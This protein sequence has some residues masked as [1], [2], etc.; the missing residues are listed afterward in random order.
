MGMERI[1]LYAELMSYGSNRLCGRRNLNIA[2]P[3]LFVSFFSFFSNLFL[4]KAKDTWRKKDKG[5]FCK[6]LLWNPVTLNR[7]WQFCGFWVPQACLAYD[8]LPPLTPYAIHLRFFFLNAQF[9]DTCTSCNPS[10]SF[11][12]PT[13]EFYELFR[14]LFSVWQTQVWAQ[15]CNIA[16]WWAGSR[17]SQLA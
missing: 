14:K 1:S 13:I 15:Q 16:K 2:A 12:I 5:R 6:K 10:H 7:R 4:K 11:W 9:S 8:W 17:L 3:F